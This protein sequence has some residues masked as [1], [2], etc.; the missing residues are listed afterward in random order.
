MGKY[1]ETINYDTGE[2]NV[3]NFMPLLIII[4]VI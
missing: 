4:T 2:K 1:K 3:D